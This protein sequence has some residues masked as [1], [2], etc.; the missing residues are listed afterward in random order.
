MRKAKLQ[1]VLNKLEKNS[2]VEIPSR[3][4]KKDHEGFNR[5]L[6]ILGLKGDID[7][8]EDRDKSTIVFRKKI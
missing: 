2:I 4:L 3:N 1:Q 7:I 5:I 6:R 8:A